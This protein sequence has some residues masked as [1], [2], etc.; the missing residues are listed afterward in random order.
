M[1]AGR[2]GASDGAKHASR[3]AGFAQPSGRT[4]RVTVHI[5]PVTDMSSPSPALRCGLR[6]S[7]AP[8][9]MQRSGIVRIPVWCPHGC[10][11][12][13]IGLIRCA[14]RACG[15]FIMRFDMAAGER[16]TMPL[17]LNRRACRLILRAPR[18]VLLK[19]FT[20][21]GNPI[22]SERMIALDRR[23]GRRGRLC[24]A[25]RG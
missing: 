11:D 3:G 6:V 25:T 5:R 22:L 24:S 1:S 23:D 15:Q 10:R 8:L 19:A 7:T 17:H 13:S 2:P 20:S 16:R 18:R 9:R 21:P 14:H 12:A 4:G